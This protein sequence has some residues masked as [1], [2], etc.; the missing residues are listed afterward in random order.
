VSGSTVELLVRTLASALLGYGA[1]CI[2]LGHYEL[3][4]CTLAVSASG[5]SWLLRH[6][7]R[8]VLREREELVGDGT[9]VPIGIPRASP[10]GDAYYQPPSGRRASV[11]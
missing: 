3:A 1:A 4:S 11:H 10:T 9:S 2:L 5:Y 7:E 8:R 6:I